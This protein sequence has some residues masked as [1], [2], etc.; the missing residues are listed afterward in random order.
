MA[1]NAEILLPL[2]LKCWDYVC[3]TVLS[4]ASIFLPLQVRIE[5]SMNH[6][7][8]QYCILERIN[9]LERWLRG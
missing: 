4:R 5:G 6:H 3:S 1:L 7:V 9:G 8:W 2:L